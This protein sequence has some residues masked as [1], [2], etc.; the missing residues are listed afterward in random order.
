MKTN[1]WFFLTVI[2]VLALTAAC[3][4][5]AEPTPADIPPVEEAAPPTDAPPVEE[6]VPPTDA[7]APVTTES[8]FPLPDDVDAGSVTDMGNGTINFQTS[9]SLPDAVTFYRFAFMDLGYTER[10]INTSITET[11]FSMVFDGHASG[12]AIVIQ[13]TDFNGSI[14]IN[15]RFDD[16]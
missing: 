10:E 6:V 8:E 15:I 5:G 11:G 2:F 9:L 1:R 14:N 4:G 3:G 7:P 13:G 12:K 16:V